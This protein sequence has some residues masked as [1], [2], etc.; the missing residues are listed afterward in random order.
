MLRI[1][2][3]ERRRSRQNHLGLA[4]SGNPAKSMPGNGSSFWTDDQ[5]V[6][7]TGFFR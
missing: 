1:A 4:R 2:C 7:P 5:K 6:D 3:V